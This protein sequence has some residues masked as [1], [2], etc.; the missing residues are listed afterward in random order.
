MS[1]FGLLLL[2]GCSSSPVEPSYEYVS[3]LSL[4]RTDFVLDRRTGCIAEIDLGFPE[5]TTAADLLVSKDGIP[6]TIKGF[7]D[8]KCPKESKKGDQ[9]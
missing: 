6:R 3:K 7:K 2:F 5:G 8:W 4:D 1:I 9:Q